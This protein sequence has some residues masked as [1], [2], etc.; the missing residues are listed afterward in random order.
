MSPL[1]TRATAGGQLPVPGID[2]FYAHEVPIESLTSGVVNE[3]SGRPP[4]DAEGQYVHCVEPMAGAPPYDTP[5][6]PLSLGTLARNTGWKS[7]YGLGFSTAGVGFKW[8]SPVKNSPSLHKS[9]PVQ[10]RAVLGHNFWRGSMQGK[11][12]GQI[13]YS[14]RMFSAWGP[15]G[16][17]TMSNWTF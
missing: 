14:G 9:V 5:S 2:N 7:I 8:K 4:I 6:L 1:W 11:R 15:L 3:C 10:A 12:H 16:P 17:C 13:G